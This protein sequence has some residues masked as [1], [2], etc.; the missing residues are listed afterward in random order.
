SMPNGQET[1]V[2]STEG[3]LDVFISEGEAESNAADESMR[4]AIGD[5]ARIQIPAA[6]FNVGPQR[7]SVTLGGTEV[8][9][10]IDAAHLPPLPSAPDVPPTDAH[11]APANQEEITRW[12]SVIADYE[13]E[14][15]A[16]G[17]EP[18][19]A[20]LYVEI[21]RIWEEQLNKPRNAAM[22]YQRAFH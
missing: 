9:P 20:A 16:I 14:A 5:T 7:G 1:D 6:A 11:F 4:A 15:K 17:N 10:P 12:Q 3:S 13:R 2:I 22:A 18:H 8:E 21:G 19:A